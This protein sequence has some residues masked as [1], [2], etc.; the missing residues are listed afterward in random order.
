MFS[1]LAEHSQN[2]LLA[3]HGFTVTKS[4]G[5]TPPCPHHSWECIALCICFPLHSDFTP[6]LFSVDQL[7]L[8]TYS[9]SDFSGVCLLPSRATDSS[10][11]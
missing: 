5:P 3:I 8:L 9:C 1:H 11:T 10:K 7:S 4:Q 6:A 2:K